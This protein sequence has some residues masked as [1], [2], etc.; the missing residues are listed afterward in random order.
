MSTSAPPRPLAQGGRRPLVGPWPTRTAAGGGR[1]AEAAFALL[2]GGALAGLSFAAG[3]GLNLEQAAYPELGLAL[4]C[5]VA[6]AAVLAAIAA[7]RLALPLPLYGGWAVLGLGLFSLLAGASVLWSVEPDGS[8][9]AAGRLLSYTLFF[10]VAVI[11]GRLAPRR[12]TPVFGALAL[13]SLA[14]CAYALATKVFPATLAAQE[15]YAR[16]QAPYGYWIATGLTAVLGV[17]AALWFAAR[18]EGH[19]LARAL[20]FPLITLLVVVLLLTYSR[21]PLVVLVVGLAL[22]FALVPLRLRSLAALAVGVLFAVPP[23]A[24]AFANHALSSEAVPLAARS[25]AGSQL[26]VICAFCLA[27]SALSGVALIY[28]S[29]RRAPSPRLRRRLGGAALAALAVVVLAAVGGLAA[30]HRGLFGT[31]SHDLQTLFNPNATPPANTPGRLTAVASV[32]ARYWLEGMEAFIHHPLLGVGAEGYAVA[33]LRYR[34]DTLTVRQAHSFLVQTLADLGVVGLLV[35]AALFAAWLTAVLRPLRSSRFA[36]AGESVAVRALFCIVFAFGLHSLVDWTW[37]V[38]GTACAALLAAGFLAAQGPFGRP[39]PPARAPTPSRAALAGAAAGA[40]VVAAAFAYAIWTPQRSQ[41]TSQQALAAFAVH[42]AKGLALA[43]EAVAQDPLSLQARFTLAA[44][45]QAAGEA[46]AAHG[47]LERAVSLFPADPLSWQRLGEYELALGNGR[48]AL[49]DLRAAV[50]LNPMAA[51]PPAEIATSVE[52]T[53][54]RN[55]YLR[56]LQAVER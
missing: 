21:G 5:G 19:A 4:A 38:P 17:F 41:E 24:F 39:F 16:L 36:S 31:V 44:V 34:H 54:L 18:R 26:G 32:R 11:A 22:W 42:P 46:G 8:F 40:V 37:E 33:R 15:T 51:A 29:G 28:A 45:Q 50:Y 52:L 48:L 56:A 12:F 25:R 23:I 55:A 13:W 35:G 20:A 49:E 47:T 1:A 9:Q 10:A 27:G 3:G 30:S 53:A 2:G 6:I 7:G 43:R 14:V